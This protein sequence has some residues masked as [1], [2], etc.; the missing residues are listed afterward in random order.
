M[1][2]YFARRSLHRRIVALTA[3][4]AIALSTLIAGSGVAHAAADL[5]AQP[6]TEICHGAGSQQTAPD[7]GKTD[8]TACI[9]SCCVGCLML[10]TALPPPPARIIGM[11]QSAGRL[12]QPPSIVVLAAGPDTT[13]HR[14]RAPPLPA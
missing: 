1:H 8:S 3:A 12:L 5:P 13:S 4:C 2:R 7:P 14:S 9:G 6:D 11:L 10:M